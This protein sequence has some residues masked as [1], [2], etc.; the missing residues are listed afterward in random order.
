MY[1]SELMTLQG[2]QTKDFCQGKF[3]E[4]TFPEQ[5][6]WRT[7]NVRNRTQLE[8]SWFP[9]DLL[10]PAHHS[11]HPFI[12]LPSLQSIL[13]YSECL[14]LLA[15]SG[16]RSAPTP[17]RNWTDMFGCLDLVRISWT[18][19]SPHAFLLSE[20]E[21]PSIPS[22][23]YNPDILFSRWPAHVVFSLCNELLI[24]TRL[25]NH[26]QVQNK[27]RA[28]EHKGFTESSGASCNS[29]SSGEYQEK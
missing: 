25:Q 7:V 29:C 17:S 1:T 4:A 9:P 28:F 11:I 2:F 13:N 15:W 10:T 20:D 14:S 18:W 23:L 22:F 21:M 12:P 24:V 8:P 16:A 3:P 19:A 26:I 6:V 27:P 5:G